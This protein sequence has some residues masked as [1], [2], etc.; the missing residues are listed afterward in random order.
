RQGLLSY[1]EANNITTGIRT[2]TIDCE[3]DAAE[4][5]MTILTDI[6]ALEPCGQHNST[7]NFLTRNC[8]VISA[9]TIGGDGKHLQL[10][11][12][13]AGHSV[14]AIAWG[15]GHQVTHFDR[16]KAIDVVYQPHLN[17][18]NGKRELRLDIRDFRSARGPTAPPYAQ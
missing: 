1:A 13:M 9:R 8:R 4:L 18:W 6:T 3:L 2:L 5:D 11:L 12:D 10:K 17:E 15:E 16:I 14:T 7:P